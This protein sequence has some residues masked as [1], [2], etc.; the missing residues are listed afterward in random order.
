MG[1]WDFKG[2]Y[3]A[4]NL[5]DTEVYVAEGRNDVAYVQTGTPLPGFVVK[6]VS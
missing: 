4:Q 2:S 5:H 3:V 1:K 6:R